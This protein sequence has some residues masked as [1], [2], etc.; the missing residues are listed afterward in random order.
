[1][2][3]MFDVILFLLGLGIIVFI[4]IGVA[5]VVLELLWDILLFLLGILSIPLLLF[6]WSI[7]GLWFLLRVL[8]FPL[9][10]LIRGLRF[11][12]K[13]WQS[14]GGGEEEEEEEEEEED[15]YKR[16]EKGMSRK[17]AIKILGVPENA[18]KEQIN[19]AF[20]AKMRNAHPDI[21]GSEKKA[22]ELN[23]AR[24]AIS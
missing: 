1:M 2:G 7:Q 24:D 12:Y 15:T 17:R 5:I 3:F 18:S 20:R 4:A 11:M 21:G 16:R 19:R 23:I 9:A 22:S 14:E 8:W 13:I 10:S 6:I